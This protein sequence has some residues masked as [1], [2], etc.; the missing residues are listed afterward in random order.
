[1]EAKGYYLVYRD[2]DGRLH[3]H[4]VGLALKI[5]RKHNNMSLAYASDF[6]NI[7]RNTLSKY[8]NEASKIPF[9]VLGKLASLYNVPVVDL[10]SEQE[11]LDIRVNINRKYS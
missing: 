9:V 10:Y 4:P 11:M 3:C 8:E 7:H 1:M 2:K 6:L 5:M